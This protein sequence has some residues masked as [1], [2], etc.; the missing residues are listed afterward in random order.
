MGDYSDCCVVSFGDRGWY[1]KGVERLISSLRLVGYFD[2]GGSILTGD[3]FDE[4]W[5]QPPEVRCAFKPMM[6]QKAIL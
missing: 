2:A 6:M 5:P 3:T 4:G 1:P